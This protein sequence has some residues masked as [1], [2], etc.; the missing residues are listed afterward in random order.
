MQAPYYCDPATSFVDDSQLLSQFNA[1]PPTLP[2]T[3]FGITQ[4]AHSYSLP[5][6]EPFHED[7]CRPVLN[8][9]SSWDLQSFQLFPEQPQM[10]PYR[11]D[12][13][14]GDIPTELSQLHDPEISYFRF[15]KQT[16][17]A[18]WEYK[19]KMMAFALEGKKLDMALRERRA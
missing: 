4:P 6:I 16:D 17:L 13:N 2:N 11:P 1:M 8:G 15:R 12:A 19:F 7:V 3:K 9:A 10:M 14:I 18:I 5:E